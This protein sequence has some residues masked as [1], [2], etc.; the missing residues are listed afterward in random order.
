MCNN[1]FSSRW[2]FRACVGTALAANLTLAMA[3][4]NPPRP[5]EG[6]P[7]PDVARELK[8]DA[9]TAAKVDAILQASREQMKKL[10]DATH[11]QLSGL[12]SPEQLQKLDQLQRPP[13]PPLPPGEDA[14]GRAGRPDGAPRKDCGQAPPQR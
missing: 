3:Q 11:T 10:H 14:V 4:A 6:P 13:R 9:A 12:L 5:P 2:F 8:L 7:K 1:N